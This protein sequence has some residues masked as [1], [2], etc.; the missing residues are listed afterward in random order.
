MLE[1]Q[2]LFLWLSETPRPFTGN[3]L[4]GVTINNSLFSVAECCSVGGGIATK[5]VLFHRHSVSLNT[6][7]VRQTV[8]N[9]KTIH[10]AGQ[11]SLFCGQK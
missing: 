2:R 3:H 8:R 11:K 9:R 10:C 1:F 4:A 6:F 5:F 7:G